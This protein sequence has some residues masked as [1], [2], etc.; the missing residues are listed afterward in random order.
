MEF[1]PIPTS[2]TDIYIEYF[3]RI[4]RLVNNSDV[5]DIDEKWIWCVVSGSLAKIYQ[6]QNKI[7]NYATVLSM[8]KNGVKSMVEADIT[9]VDHIPYLEPNY[10]KQRFINFC[11]DYVAT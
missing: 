3:T 2:A 8:Y 11:N 5:P 9:N 4:K 7:D 1:Y 10:H 6:Y